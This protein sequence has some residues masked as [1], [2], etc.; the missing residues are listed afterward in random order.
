MIQNHY[1]Y[2]FLTV[3][4]VGN[5][6]EMIISFCPI[7]SWNKASSD[8]KKCTFAPKVPCYGDSN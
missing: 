5:L 6:F 8:L 1:L 2:Y 4:W 3:K 7:L